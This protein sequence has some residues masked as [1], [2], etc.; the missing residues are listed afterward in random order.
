MKLKYDFVVRS[1]ADKMV[2]IPVGDATEDFN[3]MITLN[4]SGAFIFE[5]LKE[6]ISEERLL[7]AFLNEYDATPEQAK[8][9][10]QSVLAKLY[11]SDI[12]Q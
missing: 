11:K 3:C 8:N 5:L 1:V 9:T 6:E 10:I 7:E 2:A 12:L 4:E